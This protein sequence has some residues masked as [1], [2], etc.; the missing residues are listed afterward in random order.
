[1]APPQQQPPL[2]PLLPPLAPLAA[3]AAGAPL[4]KRRRRRGGAGA[5][6]PSFLLLLLL[7]AALP[8]VIIAQSSQLFNHD[9]TLPEDNVAKGLAYVGTGNRIRSVLGALE[10]G[11]AVHL[12][13]IGGSITWGHGAFGS[14][15]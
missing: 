8:S 1:M 2:L 5:R 13:V 14:R 10:A 9:F 4:T 12:G 11:R 7:A 3:A 6:G 15:A